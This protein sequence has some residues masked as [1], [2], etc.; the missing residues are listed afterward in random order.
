MLATGHSILDS[1]DTNHTLLELGILGGLS[2]LVLVVVYRV[3]HAAVDDDLWPTVV[4]WCFGGAGFVLVVAVPSA[5]YVEFP[6]VGHD[7]VFAY[8]LALSLGG[9]GGLLAGHHEAQMVTEA[10]ETAQT[11]AER[12]RLE[13][14]NRLLRHDV[15]NDLA[16]IGGNLDLVLE[17]PERDGASDRLETARRRTA[18]ATEHI[19]AVRTLVQSARDGPPIERVDLAATVEGEL[20]QLDDVFPDAELRADVPTGSYVRADELLGS[21]VENLVRN[22]VKHNDSDV[23]RVTVSAV[24]HDETVTLSVADNGPGIPQTVRQSIDQPPEEGDHGLGLHLVKTLVERYGGTLSIPESTPEG[25]TV[26]VELERARAGYGSSRNVDRKSS[27]GV[28]QTAS[29]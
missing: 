19:Q 6:L 26:A 9:F 1:G 20:A 10:R 23:P 3:T 5:Y 21:V 7:A 2:V 27:M 22:G 14:L 29:E 4:R 15:L 16:V 8:Q 13:Y 18:E 25:T 24:P 17:D 12:Q 11:E 28:S